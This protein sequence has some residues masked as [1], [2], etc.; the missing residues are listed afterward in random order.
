MLK[1]SGSGQ[2]ISVL[3]I[4]KGTYYEIEIYEKGDES[5]DDARNGPLHRY[6]IDITFNEE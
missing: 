2:G 1:S 6:L 5:E 3:P 4:G